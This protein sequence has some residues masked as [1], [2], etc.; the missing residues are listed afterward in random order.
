LQGLNLPFHKDKLAPKVQ[1][2]TF[3]MSS[4]PGAAHHFSVICFINFTKCYDISNVSC[5][6]FGA[7]LSLW[8]GRFKLR[9]IGEPV[10]DPLGVHSLTWTTMRKLTKIY[11]SMT[12]NKGDI[13]VNCL[14][15]NCDMHR[16]C[17]TKSTTTNI[18]D[19]IKTRGGAPF[20]SNMFYKFY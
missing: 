4:R 7:N 9:Q 20:F 14:K 3:E 19:V 12:T 5:C 1:Q 8:N 2:L 15:H 11:I 17:N 13:I 18:W 10:S 6:T 16:W